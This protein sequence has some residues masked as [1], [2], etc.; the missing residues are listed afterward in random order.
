MPVYWFTQPSTSSQ[1][2]SSYYQYDTGSQQFVRI[3]LALGR[4]GS[5]GDNTFVSYKGERSVGFS[6]EPMS[7]KPR[8]DWKIDADGMLYYK[9]NPL[10]DKP[11]PGARTWDTGPSSPVHKG[12]K[13]T[14]EPDLPENIEAK[15]LALLANDAMISRPGEPIV[16]TPGTASAADL[17][18]AIKGEV[19]RI[20]GVPVQ[21]LATIPNEKILATL[22][23]QAKTIGG[24]LVGQSASNMED[25][26]AAA[27]EANAQIG[28]LLTDGATPDAGFEAAFGSLQSAI[29]NAKGVS[30]AD[31]QKALAEIGSA[32]QALNT[33]IENIG[34]ARSAAITEQ[35]DLAGKSLSEAE[36]HATEWQT[37]ETDYKPLAEATSV[38]D[39]MKTLSGEEEI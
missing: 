29:S 19:C 35:F 37:V 39:Y 16:L 32:Q 9:G 38:D 4:S 30:G 14:V 1:S 7:T 8:S 36:A 15:H 11:I 21:D 13:V 23:S 22:T 28:E 17:S 2:F 25:A 6:A 3:R 5:D 26:L 10:S 20:L 31:V 18:T 34:E 33:A 12:S 27:E 24:D